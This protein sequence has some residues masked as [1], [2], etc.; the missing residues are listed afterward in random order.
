[1][2]LELDGIWAPLVTP[3]AEDESLDL[4]ALAFNVQLYGQT[5]LRGYVA[6]GTT[7][8][9]VHLSD[10]ERGQVIETVVRAARADDRPVIAG[11]GGHA[12][13]VAIEQ[14]RRAADAGAAALLVWPPFYYKARMQAEALI[15]Y[16]TAVADASPV[17][18]I[19]YHIPQNTG[20][21]LSPAVVGEL[22]AHPNIAGIKDSSGQPAQTIAF[23]REGGPRFR[24]FVGSTTALLAGLAA[25]AAGG[26]LAAA[27]LAPYE[28]CEVYD[29]ARAGRWAEAAEI[30]R[31][32]AAVD[33]MVAG[34]GLGALKAVLDMLG[35]RGGH[36]RRPLVR[37]D[38]PRLD[39]LRLLLREQRLLG[40]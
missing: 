35:Y 20:V 14:A 16:F 5:P 33:E 19:L 26:I 30:Y 23:L 34:M 18:V 9:F 4:E 21:N 15:D 25:G 8:E 11:V 32:V 3:F 22:A 28:C 1:M 17:P 39:P 6:L 36:P 38:E 7:G 31:R 2:A 12:T 37:P 24:V 29:H 27:N 10:E 40:C 13:R